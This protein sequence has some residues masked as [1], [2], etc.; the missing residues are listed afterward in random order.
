MHVSSIVL[1]GVVDAGRSNHLHCRLLAAVGT[2]SSLDDSTDGIQPVCSNDSHTDRSLYALVGYPSRA[3]YW[4]PSASRH[5]SAG[6]GTTEAS[7]PVLPRPV[8]AVSGEVKPD[9]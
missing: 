1:K 3:M 5:R 8:R 7:L 4:S 6:D 9:M 2:A